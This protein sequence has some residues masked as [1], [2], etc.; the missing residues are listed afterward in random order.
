VV[1]PE[2]AEAKRPSVAAL[3]VRSGALAPGGLVGSGAFWKQDGR[4][5]LVWLGEDVELGFLGGG[6]CGEDLESLVGW[7][8][9]LLMSGS[10]F[11]R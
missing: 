6:V 11:V 9:V 10:Y 4:R 7:V 1:E 2:R 8:V 3:S 5:T